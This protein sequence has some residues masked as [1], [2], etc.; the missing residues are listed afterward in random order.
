[1]T[2]KGFLKSS[3]GGVSVAEIS[4]AFV[5]LT[6][7][8]L[9]FPYTGDD[10][11]WGSSIGIERLQTLFND[12]NGRY[13]GNLI[14]LVLTRIPLLKALAI[15]GVLTGIAYGVNRIIDIRNRSLFW[16]VLLAIAV[17]PQGVRVQGVVW[18]SGFSN[19]A[20]SALVVV[21][22]LN[23]FKDVFQPTYNPNGKLTLPLVLLGFLGSLI[24][25]NITMYNVVAS[26]GLLLFTR[27]KHGFWDKN[28]IAFL[29]G[30]TLGA[31]LMFTNSAYSLIAEGNYE[32]RKVAQDSLPATISKLFFASFATMFCLDNIVLNVLICGCGIYA[33]AKHPTMA[34]FPMRMALI[35]VFGIVAVFSLIYPLSGHFIASVAPSLTGWVVLAYLLALL[36][37]AV[38]FITHDQNWLPMFLLMSILAQILPLF[39]VKPIGPRNSLPVYILFVLLLCFLWDRA[40]FSKKAFPALPVLCALCFAGWFVLYGIITAADANRLQSIENA[41]ASGANEVAIQ[42]LPHTDNVWMG[43]PSS[44]EWER[45]YKL[46]HD[47]PQSITFVYE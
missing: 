25:E 2:S 33:L 3:H 16:L 39:V 20:T 10:W 41:I 21:L 7:L 36:A 13:F 46:F 45:R 34:P 31:I 35:A 27:A 28:Q 22:Y 38:L 11:A 12:Y 6:A 47:I 17:L 26:L 37:L 5:A 40:G 43:D 32:G 42:P 24:V 19:Y 4:I 8:A 44:G 9:L 15:A 14:V 23:C 29:A 30:S 1:M 18:T